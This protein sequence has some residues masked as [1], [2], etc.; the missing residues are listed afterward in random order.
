MPRLNPQVCE[1]RVCT[2][3][4]PNCCSKKYEATL[5]P[6]EDETAS[7]QCKPSKY[8]PS[9]GTSRTVIPF[10]PGFP[11]RNLGGELVANWGIKLL[12]GCTGGS[13]IQKP[14]NEWTWKE[15]V[16]VATRFPAAKSGGCLLSSAPARSSSP[17]NIT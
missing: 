10:C 4:L 2:S 13:L 7:L 6:T 11:G 5:P 1:V 8:C 15:L 16:A 14:Y 9:S 17:L 3:V 12:D